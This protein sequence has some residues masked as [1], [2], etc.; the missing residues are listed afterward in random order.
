MED[1]PDRA[2]ATDPQVPGQAD[3]AQAQ[4]A[5]IS[6]APD[7]R[8]ALVPTVPT[9]PHAPADP[10]A[11]TPAVEMTTRAQTGP[12]PDA[13]PPTGLPLMTANAPAV[14]NLLVTPLDLGLVVHHA[15]SLPLVQVPRSHSLPNRPAHPRGRS[16]CRRS[17]RL[18]GLALAGLAKN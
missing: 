7:G 13:P 2:W 3:P 16:G 10:P 8:L 4:K 14:L 5:Q 12:A 1:A 9:A 11:P 6:L 15:P 18:P 17:L